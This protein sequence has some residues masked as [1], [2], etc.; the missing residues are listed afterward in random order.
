[1]LSCL[2]SWSSGLP[3]L[4]PAERIGLSLASPLNRVLAQVPTG[5]AATGC[6]LSSLVAPVTPPRPRMKFH[7]YGLTGGVPGGATLDGP[8]NITHYV[9][10]Q[11]S[12]SIQGPVALHREA[13]DM[14][15]VLS[16]S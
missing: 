13:G 6:R 7:E 1:M 4:R 3:L 10:P 5:T 14:R 16:Q 8:R 15:S 2:P 9:L 12:Q 11:V